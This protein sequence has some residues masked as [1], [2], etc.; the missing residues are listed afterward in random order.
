MAP[1]GSGFAYVQGGQI[2][3]APLA[4][5]GGGGMASVPV[6]AAAG[7]ATPN[8]PRVL[9]R[10]RGGLG[11]LAWSPDASRLAFVS[12]RGTHAFVGI[13]ERATQSLRWIDPSVDVDGN[14]VWSPSGDRIAFT[15]T[16]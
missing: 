15:R 5:A 1:D 6:P 13:W 11:S 4:E 8:V 7:Q 10:A 16:L 2:W 12:N 3:F 14:P 9:I